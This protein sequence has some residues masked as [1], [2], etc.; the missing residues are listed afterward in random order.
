M[1]FVG[2]WNLQLDI[3]IT[4]ESVLFSLQY[5]FY[6]V[7]AQNVGEWLFNFVEGIAI[8]MDYAKKEYF[9]QY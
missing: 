7:N 4:S 9:F 3:I 8:E 1:E 5:N 6:Y 2:L